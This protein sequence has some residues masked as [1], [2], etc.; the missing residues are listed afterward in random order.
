M[1]IFGPY[2]NPDISDVSDQ[3]DPPAESEP[4]VKTQSPAESEPPPPPLTEAEI[5]DET[6]RR[7]RN[8]R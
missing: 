3:R 5:A 2:F 8:R 4:P 7:N 6:A 1:K